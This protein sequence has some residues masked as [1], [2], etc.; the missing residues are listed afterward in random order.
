[1]PRR[2]R[3]APSADVGTALNKLDIEGEASKE[4]D[5]LRIVL[6]RQPEEWDGR[7]YDGGLPTNYSRFT[8]DDLAKLL[9]EITEFQN[10]IRG[11]AALFNA[12]AKA[13]KRRH[14]LLQAYLR[15]H[16]KKD[17]DTKDPKW[18]LDDLL[19]MDDRHQEYVY[20]IGY[21]EYLSEVS[22][23]C[24]KA[25]ENDFATVSRAITLRG[26]SRDGASRSRSAQYGGRGRGTL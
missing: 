11:Q 7:L 5:K 9:G 21:Y 13:T 2:G 4:L 18:A 1:M 15:K 19:E 17:I 3:L 24:Y 20:W 22:D 23:A 25:A 10:F 16:Y 8:D 12:C 6:P 26:H 14:R